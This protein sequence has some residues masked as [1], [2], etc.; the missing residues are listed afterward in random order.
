MYEISTA[1]H[2]T[3]VVTKIHVTS[4]TVTGKGNN[5]LL[6]VNLMTVLC[7]QHLSNYKILA[8][9]KPADNFGLE[10]DTLEKHFSS[11]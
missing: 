2:F 7:N 8:S 9:K 3:T 5:S 11:N 1:E 4:T 6:L 10:W